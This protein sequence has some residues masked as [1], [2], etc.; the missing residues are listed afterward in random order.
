[1]IRI[2]RMSQDKHILVVDDTPSIRA[3]L[4]IL[5]ESEGYRVFEAENAR[6]GLQIIQ[7]ASIHMM[8]LD[9]G[10]PDMD[11]L[12]VLQSVKMHHPQLPVSILSVR[13][14]PETK[15]KAFAL[16]ANHYLIKPFDTEQMLEMVE[17]TLH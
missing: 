4:T 6:Q 11:G 9:L 2:T 7:Q 16:G 14:D 3:F 12:D 15:R 13:H 17:A 5:L 10:L 1:M 8:T